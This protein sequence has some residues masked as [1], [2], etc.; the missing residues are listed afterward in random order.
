MKKILFFMLFVVV[1]NAKDYKY[2]ESDVNLV[3]NELYKKECGSCHIAYVPYLLPKKAWVNIMDNLQNHFGDDASLDES[4][5]SVILSFLEQNSMEKFDIKFKDKLKKE[6]IDQIAITKY[7]YYKKA[8][9]K[10]PDEVFKSAKIKSKANC[11]NCH[12]FAQEGIFA[13]SEIKY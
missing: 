2:N 6:N 4:D 9:R 11:Q 7:N 13:K 8:H 12:Q 1:L 10:I 3:D 5:E